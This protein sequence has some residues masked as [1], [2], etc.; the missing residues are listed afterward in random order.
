MFLYEAVESLFEEMHLNHQYQFKNYLNINID[1]HFNNLLN[2]NY[3][4]M[5]NSSIFASNSASTAQFLS[6]NTPTQLN[7]HISLSLLPTVC[8]TANNST[9]TLPHYNN[10]NNNSFHKSSASTV[11]AMN[12]YSNNFATISQAQ[13][14]LS[15][16]A[17]G[18]RLHNFQSHLQQTRTNSTNDLI[19]PS[20]T[21]PLTATN[22]QKSQTDILNKS[23]LID[24]PRIL[25]SFLTNGYNSSTSSTSNQILQA[26]QQSST[27]DRRSTNS[28]NS[29]ARKFM[30][31]M[32]LKSASFKRALFSQSL[33]QSG[34]QKQSQSQMQDDQQIEQ[35]PSVIV[36]LSSA[37]SSEASS[38]ST[39]ALSSTMN[40]A[41]ESTLSSKTAFMPQSLSATQQIQQQQSIDSTV[42]T[43]S[44]LTSRINISTNNLNAP[45]NISPCKQAISLSREKLTC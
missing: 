30:N 17:V 37:S 14:N 2:S 32:M 29:K 36:A 15:N 41:T 25:P 12:N 42:L 33:L 27:N 40:T 10:S 4:N 26:S 38:S 34:S 23:S 9:V 44:L 11:S 22:V 5:I 7:N 20:S 43:Q 3:S 24:I 31:T 21:I 6:S 13:R 1:N 8:Q 28:R 35:K 45:T 16:D 18:T 39:S 19:D